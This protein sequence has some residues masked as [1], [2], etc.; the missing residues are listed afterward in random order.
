[1]Q[2]VRD[3]K[4]P[5]RVRYYDTKRGFGR[6]VADDPDLGEVD[7]WLKTLQRTGLKFLKQGQRVNFGV[8]LRDTKFV[9]GDVEIIAEERFRRSQ[10]PQAPE[11]KLD[12]AFMSSAS[13]KPSR[14]HNHD[15]CGSQ[16]LGALGWPSGRRRI[17]AY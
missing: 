15:A 5:G 16:F 11:S 7:V 10:Q 9:A 13:W 1:M 3:Q 12:E 2:R 14:G 6:I 17:C 8:S 4:Q